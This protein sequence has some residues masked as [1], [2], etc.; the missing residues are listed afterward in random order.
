MTLATRLRKLAG[1][2]KGRQM[3]KAIV[4]CICVVSMLT[5]FFAH[6]C[7]DRAPEG[8][9]QAEPSELFSG[10]LKRLAPHIASVSGCVRLRYSR[11]KRELRL[12]VWTWENGKCTMVSGTTMQLA[13]RL[14]DEIDVTLHDISQSSQEVMYRMVFAYPGGASWIYLPKVESS[15][16]MSSSLELPKGASISAGKQVAVWGYAWLEGNELLVARKL[17]PIETRAEEAEWAVVI[18][19][20]MV[21]APAMPDIR[22]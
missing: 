21:D 13:E 10:D 8:V 19:V 4:I 16:I 2:Q 5:M 3:R 12:N 1:N 11:P 14:D 17:V 6:G 22:N 9:L 18:T 15:S 7:K 20:E